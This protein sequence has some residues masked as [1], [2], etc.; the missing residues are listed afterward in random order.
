[1]IWEVEQWIELARAPGHLDTAFGNIT[2]GLAVARQIVRAQIKS[3]ADIEIVDGIVG[4]DADRQATLLLGFIERRERIFSPALLAISAQPVGGAECGVSGDKFGIY[5]KRF[6][7][8]G[9]YLL[10]S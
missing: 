2:K 7:A 9:N 10:N 6:A 1:M 8:I 4:I 5:L 3:G